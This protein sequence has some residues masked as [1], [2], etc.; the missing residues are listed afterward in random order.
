MPKTKT[1]NSE[2]GFEM[3]KTETRREIEK[4]NF[5]FEDVTHDK[6][7]HESL[8]YDRVQ[9]NYIASKEYIRLCGTVVY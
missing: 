8:K 2:E 3:L 1:E 9:Y 4:H 5:T 6:A 7:N